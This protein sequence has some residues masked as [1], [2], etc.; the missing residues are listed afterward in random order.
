VSAVARP[1]ANVAATPNTASN[2]AS[3]AA[4]T[5]TA[6]IP[7]NAAPNPSPNATANAA[8]P[9]V[10]TAVR[11]AKEE[12]DAAP[13]SSQASTDQGNEQPVSSD[14]SMPATGLFLPGAA[15]EQLDALTQL[16]DGWLASVQPGE[17]SMQPEAS[18]K[19]LAT[20]ATNGKG[21]SKNS[22]DD[23]TVDSTSSKQ[24]VTS[25][26][27]QVET[28]AGSHQSASSGD[29]SQDRSLSQGQDAATVQA[30]FASHPVAVTSHV[31]ST[32]TDTAS[33]TASAP[34]HIAS[35]TATGPDSAAS[36]MT[37]QTSPV[38]NTAKLIQNM[39][40]SEMRVGMRSS[41]FGNISIST[42]TVRDGVSAQISLDHG[43][44]AKT[45]A[46]HLP[47]M[48]ARLG[49]NQSVDVRIDMNGARSGQG[50]GTTGGG[51]NGSTDDARGSR[52]Q[53]TN[54][55]S[56]QTGNGFTQSRF[57]SATA[58]A[59]AGDGR[60]NTRLDIRV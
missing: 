8:P 43:E 9:A 49:G 57:S 4:P 39:G 5:P 40:Q 48:Q 58:T 38:I 2:L 19:P 56:F 52:R 59:A 14:Q 27:P 23:T 29:Q 51:S 26:T 28:Q 33:Q 34:A 54:A 21:G 41:E 7:T 22:T 44:L 31:I 24:H 47:E 45:L 13:A 25:A 16:R 46:A 32:A 10:S 50:T 36:T 6:V 37:P 55:T 35:H 20:S 1:T 60:V 3:N 11:S 17:L 42:S 18:A 12:G 53:E 15:A 30:N